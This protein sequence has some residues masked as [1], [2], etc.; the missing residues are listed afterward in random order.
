M[1]QNVVSDP[2]PATISGGGV[3]AASSPPP[4]PSASTMLRSI[5]NFNKKLASCLLGRRESDGFGY[6]NRGAR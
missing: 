4:T 3:H 2:A 5:F 6:I 1:I